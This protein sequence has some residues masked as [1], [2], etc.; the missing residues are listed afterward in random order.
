MAAGR[1]N[2][3]HWRRHSTTSV[4]NHHHKFNKITDK[5]LLSTDNEI[6]HV[7]VLSLVLMKQN[8]T[9]TLSSC[10]NLRARLS[11]QWLSIAASG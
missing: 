3:L 7:S 11:A 5:P 4:T 8:F 1:N 6:M 2:V 10:S 9:I